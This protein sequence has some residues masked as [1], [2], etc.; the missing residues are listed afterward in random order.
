MD[1]PTSVQEKG[2][3]QGVGFYKQGHKDGKLEGAKMSKDKFAIE[4][5]GLSNQVINAKS[6]EGYKAPSNQDCASKS[7]SVFAY[8]KEPSRNDLK[9]LATIILKR[10][11]SMSL[12]EKTKTKPSST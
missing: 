12:P 3:S 7:S 5:G 9:G 8:G 10:I 4:V 11:E 6:K 1:I 2:G